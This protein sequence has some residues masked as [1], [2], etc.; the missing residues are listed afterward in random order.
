MHAQRETRE[1]EV[2]VGVITKYID[3]PSWGRRGSVEV[4]DMVAADT[5]AGCESQIKQIVGDF[6]AER[7]ELEMSE[8]ARDPES[9]LS[10]L[11][12]TLRQKITKHQNARG[13][14]TSYSW[15]DEDITLNDLQTL[16]TTLIPTEDIDQRFTWDIHHLTY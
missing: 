3:F 15:K 5:Q 12:P 16:Q 9:R 4:E 14:Q 1:K 13:P 7:F 2:W 11:E 6:I 8:L 10:Q